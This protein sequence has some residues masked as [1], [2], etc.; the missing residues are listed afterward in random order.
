MPRISSPAGF[1]DFLGRSVH[2]R[3]HAAEDD[4]VNV[5]CNILIITGMGKRERVIL[6]LTRIVIPPRIGR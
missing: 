1:D 6:L 5:I 4:K 2:A 3:I